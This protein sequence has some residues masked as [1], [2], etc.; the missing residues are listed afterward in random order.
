[1]NGLDPSAGI[2]QN[3]RRFA[4][5]EAAGRSPAYG[6]LAGAVADDHTVLQFLQALPPGKQQPNL[7][8]AA[9]RFLLESVPDA[10]TLRRLV[11]HSPEQ[12]R[13]VMLERRTQTN[14]VARCATL[15]PALSQLPPPLALIEVGASAGLALLMDR[16][17]YDYDGHRVQGLDPSAPTLRCQVEGPV[18]LPVT[19]PQIVWRRGLD[20]NPLD[21]GNDADVHWLRC[22]IWPGEAGRTERLNAAVAAA[23]SDPPVVQ[24]EDLVDDLADLVS[25]APAE[26]ATVV[27]FHSAVLAYVDAARRGAFAALVGQ[28]GVQWLPMRGPPSS[29]RHEQHPRVTTSSYSKWSP[30]TRPHRPAWDLDAPDCHTLTC[31]HQLAYP[32][33][34]TAIPQWC[35]ARPR[36]H[37]PP[38]ATG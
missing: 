4:E 8:F 16:Y 38:L 18:R 23:R 25:A 1:M 5:R 2:G 29:L 7:L 20:L 22:L 14:E 13:Q 37:A 10:R 27:V 36:H 30:H 28:L 21:P 15:L 19:V 3:Y 11:K 17:T 32:P 6:S 24:Q 34:A 31:T 33:S 35:A 26:A 12:L 9:A